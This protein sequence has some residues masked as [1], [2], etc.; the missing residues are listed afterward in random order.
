M[1][2]PQEGLKRVIGVTGVSLT[3]VNFVV[4]AGIFALPGTV[5]S[6]LG[7][8]GILAYVFCGILFA[9]IMFCYAEIGSRV[10]K[11]GGTYAYVRAAF[12]PLP[13]YVINWL[14][15]LVFA[16][17]A[18]AA[19]MNIMADSLALIFPALNDRLTRGI[20]LFILVASII[21][22]HVRGT[23]HGLGFIK[24]ITIM[25][26]IPLV[27]LILLGI[28]F[29]KGDNLQWGAMPPV[30]AFG[31]STLLLFFAFMGF[32]SALSASGEIKNP[33]K[34]VPRGILIGGVLV[35]SI[36][37]M[38]QLVTQGVLGAE[39]ANFQVAPLAAVAEK[40]VGPVGITI[41]TLTAAVSCFGNS[42]GDILITPRLIYAG[43]KDGLFPSSL[44]K[45]HPKFNTPH[46]AI[47][48]YGSLAFILAVSGG[49]KQ[50]A[51][52]ATAAILIVY[53]AVIL[54]TIKLR[55]TQ[56]PSTESTFRMPGGYLFPIL[57]I[58]SIVWLLT[59]LRWNEILT[60]I[61]F[62]TVVCGFY[63]ITNRLKK[64]VGDKNLELAG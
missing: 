44:A 39:I 2:A 34:T 22:I 60:T 30:K 29:M 33:R 7:M 55:M 50:L 27:A 19:V 62:I 9:S 54:S 3:I 56:D 25:K 49:F 4:G 13:A 53:L 40:I 48:L 59:Y 11:S 41:L 35:L 45:V 18:C 17:L 64:K 26:L 38:L 31:D 37:L 46:Y 28:W 6:S 24:F 42:S 58:A 47:I 36:Y 51:V 43:A 8:Y 61:I 10:T 1:A 57:G 23:K 16:L 52:M 20:F 5:G 12:G 63:I 21:F 15:V 32:E 14:F